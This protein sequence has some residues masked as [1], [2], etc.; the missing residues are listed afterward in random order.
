MLLVKYIMQLTVSTMP[1][2]VE[3]EVQKKKYE[4]ERKRYNTLRAKKARRSGSVGISGLKM[5]GSMKGEDS[6][7]PKSLKVNSSFKTSPCSPIREFSAESS[8]PPSSEKPVGI[9]HKNDKVVDK[10]SHGAKGKVPSSTIEARRHNSSSR[11]QDSH[12]IGKLIPQ[13]IIVIK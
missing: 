10:K 7:S 5:T 4:Q 9:R 1:A 8:S 13:R 12:L 2:S 3:N 11:K 6:I